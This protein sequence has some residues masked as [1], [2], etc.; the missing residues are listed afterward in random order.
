MFHVSAS[1]VNFYKQ[2]KMADE[3]FQGIGLSLLVAFII[4]T[5]AVQ[6]VVVAFIATLCIFSIV[7]GVMAAMV[8]LGWQLGVLES[9]VSS[10]C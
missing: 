10:D 9:S 5:L 2:K 3:A 6:N 7:L 4:L 1:W 8:I